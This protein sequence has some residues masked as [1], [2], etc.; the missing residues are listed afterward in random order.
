ME[1]QKKTR[2]LPKSCSVLADINECDS[3]PCVDNVACENTPGNYS[4]PCKD[5]YD[6]DG[7]KNGSGCVAVNSPFP[8]I[9]LTVGNDADVVKYHVNSVQQLYITLT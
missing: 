9:Q 8:A 4:C 5:G 3:K 1:T 6:G 7:R 2:L